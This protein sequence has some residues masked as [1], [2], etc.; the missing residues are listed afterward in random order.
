M[1]TVYIQSV[2]ENWV[3]LG[4]EFAGKLIALEDYQ[5]FAGSHIDPNETIGWWWKVDIVGDPD[6]QVWE[7]NLMF[8]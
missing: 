8:Q 3:Y 5:N 2:D 6:E 4:K 7:L 1:T